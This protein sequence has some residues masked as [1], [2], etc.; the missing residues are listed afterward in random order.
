MNNIPNMTLRDW[1]AGQALCG[2]VSTS[3]VTINETWAASY[4]YKYA[5][6]MMAVREK[7]MNIQNDSTLLQE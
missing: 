2:L 5:D 6:A 7:T 1:F 3:D 4:S